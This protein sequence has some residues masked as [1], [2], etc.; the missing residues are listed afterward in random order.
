M[1][2]IQIKKMA[3]VAP[4]GQNRGTFKQIVQETGTD[5]LGKEFNKMKVPVTLEAKDAEGNPY[6][7]EKTYNLLGRGAQEFQ[8]DF[9]S[10]SGRL[11][12]DEELAS[13]DCDTEMTGKPVIVELSHRKVGKNKLV[14]EIEKFLPVQPDA[15]ASN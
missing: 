7:V 14:P 8:T 2:K 10:W 9:F 5:K 4:K 12:T 3:K 1:S 6:L 15:K 11:L 13:F